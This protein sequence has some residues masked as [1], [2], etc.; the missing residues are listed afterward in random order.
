MALVT[1]FDFLLN[2]VSR[3]SG[4]NLSMY[5]ESYIKRRIDFRMKTIGIGSYYEYYQFLMTDKNE[6]KNLINTITINV[7]EFMRDKTPF[8][9]FMRE[10]L[11]RIKERKLKSNSRLLRVWSAGCSCGEEPYSIAI[12]VSEFFEKDW[13][14]SIYA[15]DIDD[16]CLH[17]ARMGVYNP[18]QLK[19]LGENLK[20]KYFEKINGKYIVRNLIKKYI[21]FKKHDLTTQPP[22]ASYFDAIFCRNVMIYFSEKQK[23]KVLNDF[24]NSLS[25]S[26]YL[27]IGRSEIIPS[28][29]KT[30]FKPIDLKE[31]IYI[32]T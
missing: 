5:R 19:N 20:L 11:P 22:I 16:N 21:K 17:S 25:D 28:E 4:I 8:E 7:T 30:K 2:K 10:V 13:I 14:I 3:L 26:G 12:C 6:L 15:T 31:K 32:K 18:E 1:D 29:F 24:Y 27:I 9:V 23:R